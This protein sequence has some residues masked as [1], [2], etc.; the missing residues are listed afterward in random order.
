MWVLV[1]EDVHGLWI[2]GRQIARIERFVEQVDGSREKP[3]RCIIIVASLEDHLALVVAV[4]SG[5]LQYFFQ[6]VR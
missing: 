5:L 3:I 2:T 6:S 1:I 4:D